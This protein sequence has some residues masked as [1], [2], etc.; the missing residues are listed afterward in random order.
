MS[1]INGIYNIIFFDNY[2]PHDYYLPYFLII[3]YIEE[4]KNFYQYAI[5]LLIEAQGGYTYILIMSI[6]VTYFVGCSFYVIACC[7]HIRL[8]VDEVDKNAIKP[9][10]TKL[11]IEMKMQLSQIISFHMKIIQ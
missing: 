2:N 11:Y 5:Y 10:T 6:G 7:E 9:M 8:M 3:P 4:R 1:V